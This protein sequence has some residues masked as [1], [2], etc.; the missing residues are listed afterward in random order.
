M[1]TLFAQD[2]ATAEAVDLT[3]EQSAST[4]TST[5]TSLETEVHVYTCMYNIILMT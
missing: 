4:L 3:G 2:V 5:N 1:D